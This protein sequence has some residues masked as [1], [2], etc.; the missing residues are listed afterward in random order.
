MRRASAVCARTQF[1]RVS[2]RNSAGAAAGKPQLAQGGV[3]DAELF[4]G[5]IARAPSVV[6]EQIG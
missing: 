4:D 2:L 1:S 6:A 3:P 5:I